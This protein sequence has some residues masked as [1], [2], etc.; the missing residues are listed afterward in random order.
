M[1][2]EKCEHHYIPGNRKME[3]ICMFCWKGWSGKQYAY[4][5][6]GNLKES[7]SKK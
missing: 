4:P 2:E 5:S 1:K 3:P 6:F 7:D